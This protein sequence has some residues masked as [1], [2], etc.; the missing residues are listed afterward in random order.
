MCSNPKCNH[1]KCLPET[2]NHVSCKLKNDYL[3]F[4]CAS[5]VKH[6]RK[7]HTSRIPV[8][9]IDHTTQSCVKLHRFLVSSELT[10]RGLLIMVRRRINLTSEQ[11]LYVMTVNHQI[12]STNTMLSQTKSISQ[13]GLTI[14]NIYKENV[15]GFKK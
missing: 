12:I 10:I 11:A 13:H 4:D 14:L 6:L 7:K 1:K 5:F 8:C 2:C 15:F 3:T 9:V